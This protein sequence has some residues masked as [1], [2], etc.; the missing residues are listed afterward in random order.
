MANKKI[1]YGINLKLFNLKININNK[2]ILYYDK[3]DFINDYYGINIKNYY[4]IMQNVISKNKKSI[5]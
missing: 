1:F 5:F 3:K 4:D 2:E